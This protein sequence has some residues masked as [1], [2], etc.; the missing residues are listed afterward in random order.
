MNSYKSGMIAHLES[1]PDEFEEAIQL[2]LSDKQ[3]LALR[4]AWL[5]WDCMEENDG[6]V[7]K[8]IDKIIAAIPSKKDNHQRELLKILHNVNMNKKYEGILFDICLNIWEKIQNQPSTRFTAFRF[9]IKITKT[10]PDLK[11]EMELLLQDK[12]TDNLSPGVK[13]S[14]NQMI[15]ELY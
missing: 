5:L 8:Y 15:N 9:M 12:F 7:V 14:L 11:G 13:K 3:P 1:N 2:A 6:R 10:H 4:A